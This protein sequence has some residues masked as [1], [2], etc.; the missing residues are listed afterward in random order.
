MLAQGSEELRKRIEGFALDE[1]AVD[2]NRVFGWLA[3][4][5][6]DFEL[7]GAYYPDLG[8]AS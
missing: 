3:V 1:W 2:F 8:C 5:N 4:F 6:F 7:F